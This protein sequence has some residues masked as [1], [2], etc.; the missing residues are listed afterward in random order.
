MGVSVLTKAGMLAVVTAPPAKRKLGSAFKAAT[1][2]D[3]FST[4]AP[5][6]LTSCGTSQAASLREPPNRP[7]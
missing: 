5:R 4:L 7:G 3:A 1:Q 2:A 6:K